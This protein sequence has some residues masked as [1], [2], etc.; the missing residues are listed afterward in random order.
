MIKHRLTLNALF[1]IA[2]VLCFAAG[3]RAGGATATVYSDADSGDGS[4]RKAVSDITG[5]PGSTISWLSGAG[6]TLILLS[7]L[8]TITDATL[9][10]SASIYDFTIAASTNAMAIAG[11]VTIENTNVQSTMTVAQVISGAGSLTKTGAGMLVLTGTNTYSGGT[12]IN[13]GT[14]AINGDAALGASSGGL[15]LDGGTLQILNDVSSARAITLNS[16]GGIFDTNSYEMSLSGVISGVGSLMKNGSGTLTL[17]GANS[18]T[19]GTIVNAGTLAVGGNAVL[20]SVGAVTVNSGGELALSG[21]Q[22]TI[23]SYSGA[24]TLSLMLRNDGKPNLIVM[25][26]ATLTGGTLAVQITPQDISLLNS[27]FTIIEAGSLNGTNFG[28]IVH[29][30]AVIFTPE[31]YTSSMTLTA[32]MVP[33]AG[34]GANADQAALGAALDKFRSSPSGDMATVLGNLYTLDTADLH[35]ALAQ[36]GPTSLMSMRGLAYSASD[37]MATALRPRLADIA[38]GGGNGGFS[39]YYSPGSQ[40]DSVSLDE[41]RRMV[42]SKKAAARKTEVPK[43][44]DDGDPWNFFTSAAGD[45]GETLTH[46]DGEKEGP[47]YTFYGGGLVAGMDYRLW[48]NAAIGALGAYTQGQASVYDPSKATVQNSSVRYG[49]YAAAGFGSLQTGLY[50]GKA[51]E[52]FNT[53]RTISFADVSR[54]ASGSPS[55]RETSVLADAAYDFGTLAEGGITAPYLSLAYDSLKTDPFAEKGAASADL[56]AG[57]MSASS[58]RSTAGL[59]FSQ[60]MSSSDSRITTMFSAGWSHEFKDQD[61]EL[62]SSLAGGAPFAVYSGDAVRDTLKLGGRLTCEWEGG[63]S[64]YLEYSGDFSRRYRANT[65]SAGVSFQF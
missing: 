34:L 37:I 33:F 29:P 18:Y 49:L 38:A 44:T 27:T 14:L 41:A 62:D 64:T 54:K 35:S 59:R 15:S 26:K 60:D 8:P 53:A 47:G 24:G 3:A 63:I 17:S 32:T 28:P 11:A 36:L 10:V 46:K 58:L 50:A 55:G 40:G 6:G 39:S 7:D 30:A 9:N 61:L 2:L 4:L 57:A 65:G 22:Q 21:Y 13:G 23:D 16:L 12:N 19:G 45:L 1:P 56:S 51:E 25:N 43:E 31:Y 5:F 52:S 48:E 42:K 20:P